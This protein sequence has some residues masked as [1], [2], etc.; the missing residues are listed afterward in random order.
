[1]KTSERKRYLD[2]TLKL[3]VEASTILTDHSQK[4]FRR[5]LRLIH[6][7][8]AGLAS[9]ADLKSEELVIKRIQQKFKG[10]TI[11]SEEDSFT[12]QLKVRGPQDE[13]ELIWLIDPLDGTNNFL[14]GLPFWCVSL[15]LAK[16]N[17]V[18]VGVVHN[19]RRRSFFK[20][21]V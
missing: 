2:F 10:H 15:A 16:G 20:P 6:K 13:E 11:V 3:A 12:R 1:M 7:G 4:L 9:E 17:E 5:P 18:Q 19:P 14:N 21:Q 8:A